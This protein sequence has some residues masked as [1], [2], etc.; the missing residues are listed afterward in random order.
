MNTPNSVV[1]VFDTLEQEVKDIG[2]AEET[3]GKLSKQHVEDK[4]MNTVLEADKQTIDHA[5]LIQEATNRSIGAFTPDFLFSHLVK[6]FQVAKQLLGEKI[7]KL[8]TGYDASYI[9]KNL[10]IPEFKKEIKQAIMD[11]INA[12][13]DEKLLDGEGIISDKGAELG[14]LVLIK[15][16][17]SYI[18]KDKIGE[19]INKQ[20]KRYGEKADTRPYRSGDRY[21]DINLKRSIHRAIKRQHSVLH[22]ADLITSEREGKGK[23]SLIFALDA[24]ASMKG[25]KIET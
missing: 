2:K 4:L 10:N 21:K 5:E 1:V 12:M 6:N 14:S 22:P 24:S 15:E 13:K 18:A 25:E 9:E 20:E 23:V 7:I 8:L 19:K 11:N 16:L 3:E 17:D